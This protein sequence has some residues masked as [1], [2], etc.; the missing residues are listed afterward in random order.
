MA[1]LTFTQSTVIF[2]ITVEI[3]TGQVNGSF[4]QRALA[5]V[6]EWNKLHHAELL[7]AWSLARASQPLPH[8]DPLE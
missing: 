6:L 7:E 1:R 2:E 5:H 8:I 4:P 3:E